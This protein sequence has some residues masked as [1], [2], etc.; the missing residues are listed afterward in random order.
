MSGLRILLAEDSE[1]DADL[2]SHQLKRL[3]VEIALVR[4]ETPGDMSAALAGS[5]WDIVI[6]D[7]RMPKFSGLA[8]LK[9]VREHN[10]DLPF[11]IVSAT[12]GEEIAVEAMRAGANDYVMKNNLPRL[13][14]AIQRVHILRPCLLLIKPGWQQKI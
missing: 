9:L 7:Y 1:E 8:A 3:G 6:S 4:V 12:I 2:L 10:S 13:L 5:A 11:I 14:P